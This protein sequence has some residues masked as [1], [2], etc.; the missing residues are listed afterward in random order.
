MMP[1]SLL[2]GK[3]ERRHATSL[4]G[5]KRFVTPRLL[6]RVFGDGKK[7]IW[8]SGIS[9]RPAYWVVRIDSSWCIENCFHPKE[10][11]KEPRDWVED[12]YQ[13]I[14]EEFGTGEKE[15]GS[16]YANAKFPKACDLGS[17]TSWGVYELRESS[18]LART[19]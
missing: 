10:G 3:I 18:K 9:T 5:Q 12:V 4:W 17:G 6:D 11:M 13:A 14:E 8:L 1:T 16:L 15:D 7:L 2:R 19:K